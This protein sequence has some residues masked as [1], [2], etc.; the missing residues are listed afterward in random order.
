LIADDSLFRVRGEDNPDLSSPQGKESNLQQG[1]FE[2]RHFVAGAFA[3][4]EKCNHTVHTSI[5]SLNK[6]R[7]TE[8]AGFDCKQIWEMEGKDSVDIDQRD[9]L[10]LAPN[11]GAT[12]CAGKKQ[13]R[14]LFCNEVEIRCFTEH[15]QV[16]VTIHHTLVSRSCR[17]LWHLHGQIAQFHDFV[18]VLGAAGN[19]CQP[20]C[21]QYDICEHEKGQA[22][23]SEETHHGNSENLGLSSEDAGC[24]TWPEGM[25]E[26]TSRLPVFA[27]T[28]FVSTHRF[29]LCVRPR[30][31]KLRDDFRDDPHAMEQLCRQVW[32]DVDDCRSV[33]FHL[34]TS[35]P[36]RL[37]SI[38]FHIVMTQGDLT[39][40]DWTMLHS[41]TLPPL[42]RHRIVLFPDGSTVEDFFRHAQLE[43]ACE[44]NRIACYLSFVEHMDEITLNGQQQFQVPLSRYVEG[45]VRVIEDATDTVALSEPTSEAE[46]M[47]PDDDE[48]PVDGISFMS[49]GPL[50]FQLDDDDPYPWQVEGFLEL[51]EQEMQEEQLQPEIIFAP[52]HQGL[53]QDEIEDFTDVQEEDDTP[54]VA[55]TFGLGLVDLGRRD[56]EFQPHNL[57]GL[58]QEILRVWQDHAQYANLVVYNVHPQPVDIIGRRAV[59]IIVVVDLPEALDL[60]VR[61]VLIVEQ[62]ANDVTARA[63]PYAA[64]LTSEA[65][66]R[67]ILV[68]L[69]LHRNCP[70]FALRPCHIRL[71]EVFMEKNVFYDFDHGT[72]CR[73]WIGQVHAQVTEAE[74]SIFN[75]E[76]FFLQ[77]HSY[78]EHREDVDKV[79]RVVCRVHGITPGNRPM[80]HRDVIIDVEW[81]YDLEWIRQMQTLWPFDSET[82]ALYFAQSATDDM[83]EVEEVVFHF[84][85]KC[86]YNPGHPILVHQ[87]LISVEE[88]PRD[89]KG[90][91]EYWAISVPDGWAGSGIVNSL[92]SRPFWFEYARQECVYPHLAVNGVRLRD[93][94]QVWQPGD[95]LRARFL[96]WQRHHMLTLMMGASN[97][98]TANDVEFTSFLQKSHFK[99]PSHGRHQP[100][101]ENWQAND[102]Q[103]NPT[104]DSFMEV[105]ISLRDVGIKALDDN[106]E[107][108]EVEVQSQCPSFSGE[109]CIDELKD[110][111]CAPPRVLSEGSGDDPVIAALVKSLHSIYDRGHS[112]INCDFM[113]VPHLHP[114]ARIACEWVPPGSHNGHVWHIFTD[115]SAK[116]ERAT[117]AIVII[118]EVCL[119]GRL[120]YARVGYA[121]GEV[122]EALGP[123]DQNAMD[124][125]ATAII[126]MVEYAIANCVAP[127]SHVYCHFDAMAVGFGATGVYGMPQR[128]GSTST[129]QKAARIL[130]T[131]L[132]RRMEQQTGVCEGLHVCAHQGHPWNEMV[133]GMAKAVWHGWQPQTPFS[134]A[135][136]DLLRHPLAEW[137]WLQVGPTVE[138]PALSQLLRNEVPVTGAINIDETLRCKPLQ[139]TNR[140]VSVTLKFAT[141]NVAT[142]AYGT[143]RG[144]GVSVKALE[145]LRQFEE[146][147]VHI[148]G[149]QESR[150]RRSQ[151]VENGPY[152]RLIAAGECGN[153]GVELWING[154]ELARAF[155]TVFAAEKDL[156]VWYQSKR[157]L[158]VRCNF[159][160]IAFDV[161]VL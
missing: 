31:I 122:N 30:K 146:N 129:R 77:V 126:A 144:E 65:S 66:Q 133:D 12:R 158:G 43:G 44:Q 101:D 59:A 57:P 6:A 7:G 128:R 38:K 84:I 97:H 103:S 160:A 53:L 45:Q 108:A 73:T 113:V 107:V 28:W 152:T 110:S 54:W 143:E 56:I 32:R 109:R 149:V 88:T 63:Q 3:L 100:S 51:D 114:H 155:K 106:A 58:L 33:K 20:Y 61:N 102:E 140:E 83:N 5:N 13:Q 112:G 62:A 24:L 153:A 159:G 116:K 93:V 130:M 91:S 157:V 136:G 156:C 42:F 89:P 92:T 41:L 25:A 48:V 137:A 67:E 161:L 145:I 120:T 76:N 34:L 19:V 90:I 94:R 86:G 10:S 148:I 17:T 8:N 71:G 29:P 96:V 11:P 134:F 80:G 138:L 147:Q 70:P 1:K 35:A 39:G 124:A 26:E 117:W 52:H 121:A 36:T 111:S 105:C 104:M 123:V 150:A 60:S 55:A 85:A 87:Q 69:D 98:D 37:P 50:M 74:Q 40:W 14:V 142:M 16:D 78:I 2:P 81:L 154:Q 23:I 82:V 139:H 47:L 127:E 68:Q 72:L 119:D 79:Q 135:S 151:C 125:E 64:R 132:E 22:S 115:G 75:V 95:V 9:D 18:R 99:R 49:A 21:R 46:T 131:V 4:Q 118:K 15:A 27:D 141:A